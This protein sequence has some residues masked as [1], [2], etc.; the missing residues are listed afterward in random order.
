MSF[1]TTTGG[2]PLLCFDSQVR[3]K[4]FQFRE[5]L[6][7]PESKGRRLFSLSSLLTRYLESQGFPGGFVHVLSTMRAAIISVSEWETF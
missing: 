6:K 4:S 1:A 7:H 2:R 5:A 3:Y